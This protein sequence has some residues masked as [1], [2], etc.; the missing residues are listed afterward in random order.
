[1]QNQTHTEYESIGQHRQPL[2]Q[3]DGYWRA[4]ETDT[5]PDKCSHSQDHRIL[6][7]KTDVVGNP[8]LHELCTNCGMKTDKTLDGVT[9]EVPQL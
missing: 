9:R 4:Y 6:F 8:V 2:L 1:M 5:H 7:G 3:Y